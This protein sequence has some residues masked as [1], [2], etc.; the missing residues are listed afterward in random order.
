MGK[1]FEKQTKTI[2]DQGERQIKSIQEKRPIKSFKKF[3]YDIND[4]PMVLKEKE[5]YDKLTE[6]SF[7]KINNLEK[8]VDTNKLV[9]KYKSN[10]TDEDFSKFDNAFDLIHKIRDGEISLNEAKD[11]QAKLKSKMGQI[12]KVQKRYLL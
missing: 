1:A 10:A 5:I 2:E 11:E 8:R 6:E 4:S 7:G 12:K 3:T 9:L